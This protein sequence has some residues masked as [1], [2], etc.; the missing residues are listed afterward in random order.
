MLQLEKLYGEKLLS[1]EEILL[2][3]LSRQI[4]NILNKY[5]IH[6]LM[7]RHIEW[8]KFF[9]LCIKQATI[10]FVINN[11]RN[12]NICISNEIF[13]KFNKLLVLNIALLEI[14]LA[15]PDNCLTHAEIR[16]V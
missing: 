16:L 4:M 14:R 8:N 3:S 1:N 11:L 13:N 7:S 15:E 6:E 5:E 9:K 2:I 10:N 12:L